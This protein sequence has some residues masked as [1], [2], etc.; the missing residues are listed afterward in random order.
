MLAVS[1][2]TVQDND[3]SYPIGVSTGNPQVVVIDS[4]EYI[5]WGY[6]L[7]HKGN[8]KFCEDRRRQEKETLLEDIVIELY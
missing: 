1:S 8:C 2:C 7:T 6:G 5:K 4:C 3:G